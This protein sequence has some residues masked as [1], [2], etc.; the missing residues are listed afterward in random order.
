MLQTRRKR[1]HV[2][3]KEVKAILVLGMLVSNSISIICFFSNSGI[4]PEKIT[5]T[6]LTQR[7]V[8]FAA[9][10]NCILFCKVICFLKQ[11]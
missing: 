11:N 10:E 8:S 9:I 5:V 7:L 1:Q 4:Q 2:I 6:N 3:L